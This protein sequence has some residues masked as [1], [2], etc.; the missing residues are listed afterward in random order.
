[1]SEIR[2]SIAF[3]LKAWTT[4]NFAN[5]DMPPR[6]KQDGVHALPSIPMSEIPMDALDALVAQWRREVYDKAGVMAP[7]DRTP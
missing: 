5:V 3:P 6:P 7:E 1:M 2:P 4:P